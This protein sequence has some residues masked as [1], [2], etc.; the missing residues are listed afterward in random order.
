MKEKLKM[1]ED[2]E[3]GVEKYDADDFTVEDTRYFLKSKEDQD[4]EPEK[5]DYRN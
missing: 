2:W 5:Y 4:K 3:I 1:I